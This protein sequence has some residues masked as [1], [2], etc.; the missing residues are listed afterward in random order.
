ML[1]SCIS[2]IGRSA[3]SHCEHTART[4]PPLSDVVLTLVEMG[5]NAD[6]LPAYAKRSR[7]MVI[8]RRKKSLS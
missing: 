1:Q 7:R 8:I 6:T 3:E 2:E 4:Q 5:F